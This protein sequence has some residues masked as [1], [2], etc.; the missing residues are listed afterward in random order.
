MGGIESILQFSNIASYIRIMAV[1]LAGAIFADAVNG[2]VAGMGNIIL[3]LVVGILLHSLNFVIASFSPAI[4]AMRLNF[5][6]FFGKFYETG[7]EEYRPFKKTG[8]EKTV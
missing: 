7:G 2:I 5:L 3:G 4:H 1:G 6:E 8:G